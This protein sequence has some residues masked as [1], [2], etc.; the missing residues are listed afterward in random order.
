M[1]AGEL[2]IPWPRQCVSYIRELHGRVIVH[3]NRRCQSR[4]WNHLFNPGG[5]RV[6]PGAT[7]RISTPC[8]FGAAKAI[9]VFRAATACGAATDTMR[10]Q[11]RTDYRRDV[12]LCYVIEGCGLVGSVRCDRATEEC[13]LTPTCDAR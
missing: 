1:R 9:R 13:V 11:N 12:T 5:E 2:S 3:D 4:A 10:V 7:L 8:Y 6:A